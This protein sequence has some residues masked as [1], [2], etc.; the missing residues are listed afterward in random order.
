MNPFF[1]LANDLN[2]LIKSQA[3]IYAETL[4]KN[5]FIL[6]DL[7]SAQ[8]DRGETGFETP[9]SPKYSPMYA[10]FKGFETP[11]LK[12]EGDFHKSIFARAD[13]TGVLIDASD[14][15]RDK[16]IDKYGEDV[17]LPSERTIN[18]FNEYVLPHLMAENERQMKKWL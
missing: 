10:A 11:N 14:D 7:V 8:M 3:R 6:S 15:K 5:E 12:L 4:N 17:L 13:E 18:E 2:M 16:L 1:E 9:I